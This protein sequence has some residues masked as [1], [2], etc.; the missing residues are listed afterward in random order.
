M[1]DSDNIR[2]RR[3]GAIIGA[4]SRRNG[5][6]SVEM[7]LIAPIVFLFFFSMIVFM[8]THQMRDIAQYAAYSGARTAIVPGAQASDADA[9]ARNVM[10]ISS[11]RS[12]TVTVDPP[13]LTPTT[14]EV[15]VTVD[16]PILTNLWVVT[17]WLPANW[18]LSSSITLR[19]EV[20]S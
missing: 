16:I 19:R 9:A 3:R 11:V 6:A 20:G 7:A 15:T 12:Y 13:V 1:R 14:P 10:S 18:S 8:Q 17:P 2:I 5:A 4:G